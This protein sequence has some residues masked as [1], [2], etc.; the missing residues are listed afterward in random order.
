[1][2]GQEVEGG[3]E[4]TGG[5]CRDRLAIILCML[6]VRLE[7]EKGELFRTCSLRVGVLPPSEQ[8]VAA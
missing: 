3:R 7:A 5:G 6:Y 4:G 1:M 2:C 8:K